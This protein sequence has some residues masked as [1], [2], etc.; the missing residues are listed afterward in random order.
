[1]SDTVDL[2]EG[3]ALLKI[4]PESMQELAAS[5][6]FGAKI[7][8]SWVFIRADL[9]DWLREQ[10][11][12]QQEQRRNAANLDK[13]VPTIL[14]RAQRRRPLPELPETVGEVGTSKVGVTA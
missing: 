14:N 3:A 5:G 9:I 13:R 10:T 8:K 11:R 7:G 6:E 2:N 1:M 12:K 4:S